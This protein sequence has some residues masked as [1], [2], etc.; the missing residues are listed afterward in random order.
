VSAKHFGFTFFGDSFPLF[1][2]MIGTAIAAITLGPWVGVLV[3]L[4]TVGTEAVLQTPNGT[5]YIVILFAPVQLT[6]GLIWGY[7]A[8]NKWFTRSLP[9][10]ISLNAAVGV[11][12]S[13]VAFT[14]ISVAFGNHT[15]HPLVQTQVYAAVASG[16]PETA[17]ILKANLFASIVDKAIAGFIAFL[18]VGT[19]LRKCAPA[20]VSALTAPRQSTGISEYRATLTPRLTP[21]LTPKLAFATA[22]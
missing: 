17:A 6:G 5:A 19:L 1:F 15:M 20:G 16:I 4:L 7:G 3:G 21:Q 14:I 10:F 13:L 12:C 18:I 2:D 9:Q 11:A 8:R 22:S